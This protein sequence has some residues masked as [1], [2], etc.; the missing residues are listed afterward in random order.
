MLSI[1][2][3]YTYNMIFIL[4]YVWACVEVHEQPQALALAFLL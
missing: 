1:N 4:S 3:L 2:V